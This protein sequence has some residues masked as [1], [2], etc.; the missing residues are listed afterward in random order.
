MEKNYSFIVPTLNPNAEFIEMINALDARYG[1]HSNIV[2]VDSESDCDLKQEFKN[3]ESVVFSSIERKNFNHGGTRNYALKYIGNCDVVIYLTQ[4]SLLQLESIDNIDKY[5]DDPNVATVCARQLPHDAANPIAAH[6]R[7]FNYPDKTQVKSY[8][9]VSEHGIKSA[10]M[11]N[12]FSAYRLSA[13]VEVGLFPEN[14]ILCEDMFVAGRF[15]KNG[16]KNVYAADVVCKHS[17]NYSPIEEFKRYFDIGVFHEMEPWI[18][19]E[20][21]G[22]SG[23]GFRFIRSELKYLMK[24]APLYL[25]LATLNNLAKILGMKLGGK[26]RALPLWLNRK[27]SMHKSFWK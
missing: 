21:G 25:P 11:S 7:Y 22:A 16:Y 26:H 18:R 23:E 10:F 12:S 13:L 2:I 1:S 8:N 6:A 19:D 27:L 20:F 15:I 17:H 9:T 3:V 14:T 4:D 24:H 5:F